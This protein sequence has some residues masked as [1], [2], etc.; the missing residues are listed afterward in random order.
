LQELEAQRQQLINE[1]STIQLQMETD[2]GLGIE[3][4]QKLDIAKDKMK[5]ARDYMVGTIDKDIQAL[6]TVQ[7]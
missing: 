2:K 3:Q 5:I 7:H 4:I 1:R 6:Q